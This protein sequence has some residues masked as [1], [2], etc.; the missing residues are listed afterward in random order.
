MADAER[1]TAE[2]LAEI[3]NAKKEGAS[4]RLK[5]PCHDDR[6]ASLMFTKGKDRPIVMYCQA[7]C[8]FDGVRDA[9]CERYELDRSQFTPLKGSDEGD[10]K[11]VEDYVYTDEYW[12]PI[13]KKRRFVD[14]NG[15]KTFRWMVYD[16]KKGSFIKS[17]GEMA[18]IIESALYKY[19]DV[20]TA[21]KKGIEVHL[22]E[23][24]KAVD[25]LRSLGLVSTC[26][27]GGA[28]KFT[29]QH[30]IKL[31]GANVIIWADIDE[32]GQNHAS[33]CAKLLR[34]L[35]KTIR[36]VEAATGK[37]KEDAY[38]HFSA[39]FGASDAID[40]GDLIPAV[41]HAVTKMH[42]VEPTVPE[43]YWHPYLTKGKM[44]LLDADGGTGKSTMVFALA[45]S[46]S[47][48]V[49]PGS[50]KN[51]TQKL[52]TLY[53]GREDEPGE[54]ATLLLACG[55]DMEQIGI[56]TVPFTLT[57]E[58]LQD[59]KDTIE[60]GKY[61]IVIFDALMYYMAGVTKDT[62]TA[63]EVAPVLQGL[64][65]V[66]RQTGA[67]ILN[68][69]HT[70]KGSIGKKA[71]DMGLGS[72]Q[73]RNTHRG[74]LV[75]RE[76]PTERGVFVVTHEKGS[77]LIPKGEPFAYRRDGNTI[78]WLGNVENPFEENQKRQETST[79]TL[80]AVQVIREMAANEVANKKEVM[81]KIESLGL[82]MANYNEA[83]A[84]L[85]AKIVRLNENPVG[86]ILLDNN[87]YMEDDPFADDG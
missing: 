17:N 52:R 30:A 43:F 29:K 39:G 66:A 76:H 1:L 54:I 62:N 15:K 24:E 38:D 82:S 83:M 69:R 16:K 73:F 25:K 64:A 32:P 51:S 53:Y 33:M 12:I 65:E 22:C 77:L 7:G 27:T 55:A 40:R 41:G 36:V 18:S 34:G 21:I 2:T 47:N 9:L 20:K 59:V 10:L 11:W 56:V 68:I 26:A 75:L 49:I 48:G 35:A 45:A 81:D 58:G 5:C 31:S 37:P 84:I 19:P 3:T 8:S 14:T 42:L 67:C 72:V 85:N 87:S 23:G 71:K 44:V 57:E 28:G 46:F 63:L 79:R 78:Y 80:Q 60:E 6:Q 50:G 74:Q 61:D 86:G 13:A 70:S 4:W